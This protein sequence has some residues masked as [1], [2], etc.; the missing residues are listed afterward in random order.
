MD[1]EVEFGDLKVGLAPIVVKPPY[2]PF[3][4]PITVGLT[5][6][7]LFGVGQDAVELLFVDA[8]FTGLFDFYL[9][10]LG[11]GIVVFQAVVTTHLVGLFFEYLAN[12]LSKGDPV[13]VVIG[14]LWRWLVAR[15]HR[16]SQLKRSFMVLIWPPSLRRSPRS[17]GR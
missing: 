12:A 6:D 2:H 9:Q 8:Q 15:P 10:P 7:R 11:I 13:W 4:P 16:V 17:V 5:A 1:E 14:A 3:P